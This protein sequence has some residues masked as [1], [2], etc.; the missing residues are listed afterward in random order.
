MNRF[1]EAIEKSMKITAIVKI[2]ISTVSGKRKKYGKDGK[3]LK[4][5][6]AD[7]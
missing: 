1:E 4:F 2:E 7:K 5:R 6:E 3:E